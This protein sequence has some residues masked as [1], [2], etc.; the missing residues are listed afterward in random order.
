M[1]AMELVARLQDVKAKWDD[2]NR[3]LNLDALPVLPAQLVN[4][5]TDVFIREVLD[6]FRTHISKF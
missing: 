4:L 5:H 6:P 1:F 2:V 3:P